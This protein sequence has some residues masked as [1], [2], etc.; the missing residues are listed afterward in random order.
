MRVWEFGLGSLAHS[1]KGG[2]EL[3]GVPVSFSLESLGNDQMYVRY[4]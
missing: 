2:W 4:I 3:L 1:Q